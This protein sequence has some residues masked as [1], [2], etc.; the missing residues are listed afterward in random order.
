MF[1]FTY[2]KNRK[3]SEHFVNNWP[4]SPPSVTM[5]KLAMDK[6]LSRLPR[7]TANVMLHKL[8]SSR[9]GLLPWLKAKRSMRSMMS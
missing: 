4:L 3:K 2:A 8:Q 7:L 1:K 9:L 6:E 5:P